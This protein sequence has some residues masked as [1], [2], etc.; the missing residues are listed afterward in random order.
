MKKIINLLLILILVFIYFYGSNVNYGNPVLN[1][2]TVTYLKAKV[3]KVKNVKLEKR[4][5]NLKIGL[6][7]IKVKILDPKY[8][9]QE[10]EIKNN[11]S[12]THSIYVEEGDRVIVFADEPKGVQPYY[13]LYNYDRTLPFLLGIFLFIGLLYLVGGNKGL[14]SAL[15][16]GVSIYIIIFFM[17]P[18]LYTGSSPMVTTII[19]CILCSIYSFVILYGY[20]IMSLVNL[21]SIAI[22]F[23]IEGLLF[24]LVSIN[25]H[26]NGFNLDDIEGL[27]VINQITGL[28]IGGLLFAGIAISTYGAAKDISVSVSSSLLEIK[29]INKDLTFKSLFI[30]GMNIGKDIIGTMVDTLIFAF[31]GS[32]ISTVLIF[33]SYGV[34]FNQLVNSN[35]FAIEIANGIIATVVLVLM[36]PISAYISSLLY[37]SKKLN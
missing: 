17:I 33:I 37:A 34:K 29:N 22:A 6:Q 23:I 24:Y 32:A 35:F 4:Y 10:I 21:I 16:L 19:T 9:K 13:S 28:Q 30:S 20:S 25:L 7:E 12:N 1:Q 3:V 5:G 27:L 14:K 31:L 18:K 26:L 15:V 2:S 8:K 11:L 36:V